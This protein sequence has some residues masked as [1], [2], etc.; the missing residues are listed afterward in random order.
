[1]NSIPEPLKD[2]LYK[3]CCV[4]CPELVEHLAKNINKPGCGG[5]NVKLFKTQLRD[6]IHNRS[7]T[8]EDFEEVTGED[9]DCYEGLIRRLKELW[10][11]LFPSEEY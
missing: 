10:Q 9:F 2:I 6:A 3:Y 8:L 7:I 4:E 11:D 1:M 5:Y